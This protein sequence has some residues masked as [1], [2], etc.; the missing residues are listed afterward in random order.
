M[1]EITKEFS[2]SLLKEIQSDEGWDLSSNDNIS[3][4]F[5][6]LYPETGIYA[7]K[8]HLKSKHKLEELFSIITDTKHRPEYNQQIESLK[9]LSK[10]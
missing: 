3:I 2:E 1:T 6:D 8:L 5:K 9:L 10:G 4:Y 7:L